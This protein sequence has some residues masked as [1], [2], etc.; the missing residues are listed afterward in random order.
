MSTCPLTVRQMLANMSLSAMMLEA[1]SRGIP[2]T[3][4]TVG[5]LCLSISL[6]LRLNAEHSLNSNPELFQGLDCIADIVESVVI[7]DNP[8]YAL[9]DRTRGEKIC[10]ARSIIERS[11]CCDTLRGE[12]DEWRRAHERVR[13]QRER[14]I[15]RIQD[16]LGGYS[17]TPAQPEADMD[18]VMRVKAIRSENADMADMIPRLVAVGNGV[19]N[20]ACDPTDNTNEIAHAAECWERL[21]K[22]AEQLIARREERR[23]S[24]APHA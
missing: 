6:A 23:E 20:A 5:G 2:F 15:G 19:C 14:D 16:A 3:P 7:N 8:D 11:L 22:S 1:E 9:I 4:E 24:E 10:A 12:R 17:V 18:I 13:S 21:T